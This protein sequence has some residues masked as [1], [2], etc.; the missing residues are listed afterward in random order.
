MKLKRLH[1][2]NRIDGQI[3]ILVLASLVV[4]HAV[5]VAG[6][7]LVHHFERAPAVDESP[8]EIVALVRLA[9]AAPR[10]AERNAVLARIARTFPNIELAPAAA[11]PTASLTNWRIRFL[12]DHLGP[13]FQAAALPDGSMQRLAIRLPDGDLLSA[14]LPLPAGPPPLGGPIGLAVLFLVVSTTL[15]LLWTARALR[16]PLAGFAAA[17]ESFSLDTDVA[18]LP[19]RGP[20]EVRAV[21]SA[22]NRMRDRIRKLVEDRTRMLS[23]LSHDLR[24]P[25]TRLRLRSEFIADEELR[26]QVLGDLDQMKGMTE[27]VLSFLRDSQAR[28]AA[29]AIDLASVLQTVCDQY[30]DMGRNVDYVG[31]DHATIVARP[32]DLQRAVGNLVDNA[33]RYGKTVV[34]RLVCTADAV[35]T[36]VEDDGPGIPDDRKAAMLEAFVRGD[37]ARTMDDRSGFGLGLSISRAIA[38]AHSGALTLHDRRP[39]GLIA[40]ITLPANGVPAS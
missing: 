8:G 27:G 12:G 39:Q 2:L 9:A 33:V 29:I 16:A 7:F 10:G 23:A 34:V 35:T 17:A 15:L 22:F 3:A 1:F 26:Q 19:E 36:A 14:R 40:R 24:T 30:A 32:H 18:T 38:E 37:E 25:I 20:E 21:A 28:E 5:A 4:I 31:P 6:F 13:D 11:M